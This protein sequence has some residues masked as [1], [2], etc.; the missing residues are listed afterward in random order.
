MTYYKI[1]QEWGDLRSVDTSQ[2]QWNNT[3]GNK[4]LAYT[5]ERCIAKTNISSF[6]PINIWTLDKLKETMAPKE[7]AKGKDGN[8]QFSEANLKVAKEWPAELI[9]MRKAV[10][11][12][13]TKEYIHELNKKGIFIPGRLNSVLQK[14][15]V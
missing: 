6:E 2:R 15:N 8:W 14:Y 9:R 12:Q 7:K 11:E 4:P 1:K 13:P 3:V 10:L 5:I